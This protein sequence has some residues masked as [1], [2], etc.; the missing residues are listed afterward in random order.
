MIETELR[1]FDQVRFSASGRVAS[2]RGIKPPD[3]GDGEPE[4]E[5]RYLRPNGAMA[6]SNFYMTMRAVRRICVLTG[7]HQTHPTKAR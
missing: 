4:V 1:K 6:F 2:V 3:A 5:L 7:R